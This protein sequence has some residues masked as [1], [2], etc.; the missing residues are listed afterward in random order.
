M[1]LMLALTLILS[2]IL[3][4]ILILILSMTIPRS[5][6]PQRQTNHINWA[7]S[8]HTPIQGLV[9]FRFDGGLKGT[10]GNETPDD[11]AVLAV[12]DDLV[13][14]AHVADETLIARLQ[15]RLLLVGVLAVRLHLQV[16]H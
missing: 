12:A 6:K 10:V 2:L 1:T 13:V 5:P 3:S 9:V 15:R 7:Q 8:P 11:V 14:V 16:R 4:L